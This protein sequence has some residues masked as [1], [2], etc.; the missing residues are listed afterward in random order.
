VNT[1]GNGHDTRY[2]IGVVTRRPG[3]SPDVLRVWE[4][5]YSVVT[6]VRS[7][8]GQRLYSAGDIDKLRLLR[9]LVEGGHRIASVAGLD[10]ERLSA[11]AHEVSDPP[12]GASMDSYASDGLLP[13]IV[14]ADRLAGAGA[15]IVPDARA[16]RVEL[17]SISPV[18]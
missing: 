8:G 14:I 13:A 6:P 2:P 5:R 18:S 1:P 16:F 15:V 4:R 11:L 10:V 7:P 9:R 17:E 3:L 12:A